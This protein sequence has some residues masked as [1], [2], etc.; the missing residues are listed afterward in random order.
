MAFTGEDHR[1]RPIRASLTT[2]HVPLSRVPGLIRR[3]RV[4]RTIEM[5]HAALR[6][7]LQIAA[8][9]LAVCGLNPHAGESGVLGREEIEEIA[10][11][12]ALARAQGIDAEGPISAETAFLESDRFDLIV[13]MYHDQALVPLKALGFGRCVNWT[14]GLPIVRTSVDHGTA[15][16]LVGTG[17]ANPG[18][19]LAALRLAAQ[20][21]PTR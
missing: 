9:R 8:P 15:D 19:L 4:L 3:D 5:S 20:L 14:L 18:S 7:Q 12:C 17:R 2:V 16:A 21:R 11:A 10:P 13:A 1:G 6:D